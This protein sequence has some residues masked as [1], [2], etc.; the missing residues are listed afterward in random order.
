MPR[1]LPILPSADRGAHRPFGAPTKV[2][3]LFSAIALLAGLMGAS[4]AGAQAGPAID[5]LDVA[6]WPEYDQDAVLV[7]YR[8]Q[9]S[10]ETSLPARLA[11]PIPAAVGEPYAVATRTED[12]QLLVAD[13]TRTV[14]GDWAELTIEVDALGVQVEF[15]D[16][17][18]FRGDQREYTFTWPGGPALGA[19]SY[20]VQQ[21][22]G[23]NDLAVTPPGAASV[24]V[25]GLTYFEADLGP[26]G[27]TSSVEISLSYSKSTPGLTIDA[28]QPTGPLEPLGTGGTAGPSWMEWLPWVA[29]GAGL[30]LLMGGALW[31]W[32]MNQGPSEKRPR[33]RRRGGGKAGEREI[34]ASPVYCHNCGTQAAV[35]DRFCRRCGMRLRQ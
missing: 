31:Y 30:V 33:A 21:P 9:L 12:E 19:L 24:R 1:I 13:F 28:L 7:I 29:G 26:Q 34:D 10:P 16:E 17:L 32:R 4:P 5:R 20:E 14:D 11:I 8:L 2:G 27:V 22:F 3:L 6:L 18:A 23:V 25:D 15:Y 35:S